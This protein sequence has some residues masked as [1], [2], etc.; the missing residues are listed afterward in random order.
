MT[1]SNETVK[2]IYTG[3]GST[4]TFAIP[5]DFKDNDQVEV[6]LRDENVSPVT[7][8]LQVVTTNYTITGGDPGT[9][10]EM[11]VAPAATEKLLIK[12]VNP[13]TQATD[14]LSTGPFPAE[15]HE[16]ALDKVTRL[17]QENAEAI[18]RAPKLQVTTSQAETEFPEAVANFFIRYDSTG[19]FLETAALSGTNTYAFPGTNGMLAQ[20]AADTS[21][22]RTL[23]GTANQV[24][25]ADGTGVSGNPTFTLSSTLVL[26]GTEGVQVPSGTTAERPAS[27]VNGDFRYNSTV[28]DLEGYRNGAWVPYVQTR[29]GTIN[30][31]LAAGTTTNANDSIVIQGADGNALSTTNPGFVVCQSATPGQLTVFQITADV[32]IDLTGAHWGFG[33]NGDLTDQPLSVLFLNN[34]G[35]ASWGVAQYGGRSLVLDTEDSATGTDINLWNEVLVSTALTADAQA[36]HVGYFKA[37]F[38]DTGGAA[39][40]LWSVQTGDDDLVLGPNIHNLRQRK[41][42]TADA[43]GT[44]TLSD[45]TFSNLRAGD[46]ITFEGQFFLQ[47]DGSAQTDVLGA[48]QIDE[49]TTQ[50]KQF[51]MRN[52][53][54][55]GDVDN[56]TVFGMVDIHEYTLSETSIVPELSSSADTDLLGDS[57]VLQTYAVLIVHGDGGSKS[58]AAIFS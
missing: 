3:N 26:P 16:D 19:T 58:K 2:A 17:A 56:F 6:T 23:T 44:G 42:L 54:S 15:S 27:P 46:V 20:T 11:I 49:G 40:D 13:I 57:T 12:R 28:G 45:I 22:A 9:N 39:E 41:F 7:E 43:T 21:A 25:I 18:S 34:D 38:D 29:P 32:T 33:T 10:V 4:T 31:G 37:N 36:L 1:V 35:A 30:I 52:T 51:T 24:D 50:I 53:H 47:D 14:Y 55:G 8:T 5:F 48:V